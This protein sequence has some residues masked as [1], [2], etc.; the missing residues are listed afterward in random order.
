M[1]IHEIPFRRTTSRVLLGRHTHTASAPTP[2]HPSPHHSLARPFL[3][4]ASLPTCVSTSYSTRGLAGAE[5]PRPGKASASASSRTHASFPP[6]GLFDLH[7]RHAILSSGAVVAGP[8]RPSHPR[9][10]SS[11]ACLAALVHPGPPSPPACSESGAYCPA[12]PWM[13]TGQPCGDVG[14]QK[15]CAPG[16]SRSNGPDGGRG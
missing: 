1:G 2:P 16:E 13:A 15:F 4:R 12:G 11:G 9:L 3:C 7:V 14:R 10:L 8:R 5:R 6:L